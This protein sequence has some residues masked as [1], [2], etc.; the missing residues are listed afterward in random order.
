MVKAYFKYFFKKQNAHG[1]HSPFL[2]SFYNDV[3]KKR[4]SVK[5]EDIEKLRKALKKDKR[6]IKITDLGA[7][8]RVSNQSTRNVSAI[9]KH[10]ATRKKYGQLISQII[11][12]YKNYKCLELGTSLGIC[13]AYMAKTHQSV[14]VTTIEGCPETAKIAKENF[15]KLQ[16]TNVDLRVGEFTEELKK[17]SKSQTQFDLI[18]IDGNHQY[19]ATLAYFEF[20]LNHTSDDAFIIFDDIHW[21]ESMEKAWKEIR[22]NKAINVSMDLFQFGI[23]C[24]RK[25]QRKQHFVLKMG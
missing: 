5:N 14:H 8:S 20:A 23:I 18:F 7:G 24:K 25:G 1:L 17:I 4:K 10:T 19:E 3:I 6:L 13:T 22:E 9:V 15:L 2:F 16:L 21:N 12:N 11:A